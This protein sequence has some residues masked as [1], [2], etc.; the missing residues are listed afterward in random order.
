MISDPNPSMY[1]RSLGISQLGNA[2]YWIR[3]VYRY[4]C[5]L[6]TVR[7][8]HKGISWTCDGDVLE[9]ASFRPFRPRSSFSVPT[10]PLERPDGRALAAA[11]ADGI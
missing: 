10:S 8:E 1:L 7:C 6:G 2:L 11:P 9:K 4:G 3:R 5:G